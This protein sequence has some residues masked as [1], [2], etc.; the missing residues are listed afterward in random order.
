MWTKE[1]KISVGGVNLREIQVG[2][3][4]DRLK[5]PLPL[6]CHLYTFC[7]SNAW[8]ESK[9][10]SCSSGEEGNG[11]LPCSSSSLRTRKSMSWQGDHRPQAEVLGR[12]RPENL[13]LSLQE[14]MREPKERSLQLQRAHLLL[15]RVVGNSPPTFSQRQLVTPAQ[16][17]IPPNPL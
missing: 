12:C 11:K 5:H 13:Q 1:E 17:V 8:T 4:Q 10:G 16:L 14:A 3:A 15:A 7:V 9:E 6:P 2:I